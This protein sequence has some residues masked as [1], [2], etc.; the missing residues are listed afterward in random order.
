M[1]NDSALRPLHPAVLGTSDSSNRKSP[2]Q[3]TGDDTVV[4]FENTVL[5][6]Q[7]LR[8]P[9]KGVFATDRD[10]FCFTFFR[11]R[12]G[13]EFSGYFGSSFWSGTLFP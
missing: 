9:S 5:P 10:Q 1:L 8:N 4:S 13:P 12:T 7:L 2:R 6:N 3:N 11:E